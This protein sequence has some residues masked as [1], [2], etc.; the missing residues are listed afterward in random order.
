MMR[1]LSIQRAAREDIPRILS[2]YERAR[3][4]MEEQGNGGQ[5]GRN[6]PA[7]E[8]VEEDIARESSYL[9]LSEGRVVGVFCFF[10]GEEPSYREITGEGWHSDSPYG[11]IHRVA[12][13]GSVRGVAESCF[14]FCR[15]KSPYLRIDTHER[16]I[17]MQRAIRRFGFRDCGIIRLREGERLAFDYLREK[18]I[19][20]S[21]R[22]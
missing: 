22:N 12:S 16:N 13:D 4:F 17:P 9:L 18:D 2:I 5:W 20:C 1:D 21:Q 10:I 14:S 8:D 11:V 19:D 15:E 3:S 7:R 6:Y